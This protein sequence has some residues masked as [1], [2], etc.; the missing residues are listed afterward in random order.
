M[1]EVVVHNLTTAGWKH[2]LASEALMRP[3]WT[4]EWMVL[5]TEGGPRQTDRGRA[6][7]QAWEVSHSPR[8][9]SPQI[10]LSFIHKTLD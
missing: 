9:F 6:V 2:T 5:V 3:G 4:V 7:V 10:M 8:Q 1:A